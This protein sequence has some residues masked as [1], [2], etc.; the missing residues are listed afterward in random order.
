ML[1]CGMYDYS[2]QFAFKVGLPAKSGVSG[3]VLLVIPN[4]CGICCYAPP[5]D[6]IGN[7][8]KGIKFCKKLV[9][10]F[11]FHNFDNKKAVNDKGESKKDPKRQVENDSN[12]FRIVNMLT[13]AKKGD[14]ST[15]MKYHLANNDEEGCIL[16]EADYDG[17]TALLRRVFKFLDPDS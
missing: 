13:A 6:H 17:R 10:K 3:T 5:L 7:S 16:N 4:L 9:N 2:G 8:T 1:S 12:N 15:L 14:C 11:V